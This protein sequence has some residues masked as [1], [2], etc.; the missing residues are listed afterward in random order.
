MFRSIASIGNYFNSSGTFLS[1]L[2]SPI[3]NVHQPCDLSN[4]STFWVFKRTQASQQS[5]CFQWAINRVQDFTELLSSLWRIGMAAS[6][7]PEFHVVFEAEQD[8]LKP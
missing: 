5:V 2:P 3:T 4:L 8:Q 6:T 7:R 1:P